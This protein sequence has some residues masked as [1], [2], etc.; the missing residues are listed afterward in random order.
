MLDM[1]VPH[2]SQILKVSVSPPIQLLRCLPQQN[3]QPAQPYPSLSGGFPTTHHRQKQLQKSVVA[4][5]KIQSFK[6]LTAY[7]KAA[8]ALA[9]AVT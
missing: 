4:W 3:K 6:Y 2:P 1:L 8:P 9:Y 5:F 7:L